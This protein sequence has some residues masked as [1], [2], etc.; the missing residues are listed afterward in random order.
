MVINRSSPGEIY[1][2]NTWAASARWQRPPRN[3]GYTAW[4][5]TASTEF[6]SYSGRQ[7][8]RLLQL[9]A[10]ESFYTATINYRTPTQISPRRTRCNRALCSFRRAATGIN[11][12]YAVSAIFTTN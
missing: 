11:V 12:K 3:T 9:R 2:D 4:R 7:T 1:A 5:N 6:R 10:M 8:I